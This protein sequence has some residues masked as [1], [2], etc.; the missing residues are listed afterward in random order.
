MYNLYLIKDEKRLRR[1]MNLC[2]NP[3]LLSYND[4]KKISKSYNS[5]S[6]ENWKKKQ[7]LFN[8]LNL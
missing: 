6:F 3:K 5:I 1:G 4:I 7:S 8:I 2:F